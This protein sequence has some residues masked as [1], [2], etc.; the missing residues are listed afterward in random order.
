MFKRQKVGQYTEQFESSH[1]HH[2]QENE[3][4]IVSV[5]A[6]NF[7][8]GPNARSFAFEAPLPYRVKSR[9]R[10]D[11]RW[12]KRNKN[13]PFN[14]DKIQ[15]LMSIE[16]VDALILSFLGQDPFIEFTIDPPDWTCKKKE[17]FLP[18]DFIK[19]LKKVQRAQL[20]HS[21]CTT[22]INVWRVPQ[23]DNWCVDGR[24]SLY[25][26]IVCIKTITFIDIEC[27]DSWLSPEYKVIAR[28]VLQVVSV[29][30]GMVSAVFAK[31]AY[32]SHW[33]KVDSHILIPGWGEDMTI[34]GWLNWDGYE[35]LY[36]EYTLRSY[37]S[38]VKLCNCGVTDPF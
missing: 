16:G 13:K 25:D 10:R 19:A 22:A 20:L 31:P 32:K 29:L 23:R 30:D 5:Y 14:D 28:S 37:Y 11:I 26:N 38:Q 24:D 1:A 7:S 33:S 6:P 15:R 21:M 35:S 12:A 36:R 8:S 18:V 3:D 2:V 4:N 9:R 34:P 27:F 17:E